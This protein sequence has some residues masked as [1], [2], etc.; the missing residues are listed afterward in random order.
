[1]RVRDTLTPEAWRGSQRDT[2]PTGSWVCEAGMLRTVAEAK[3]VDL[4]TRQQY[5][6]FALTLE[7][8][9]ARGGKSGI[10]LQHHGA[11]VWFRPLPDAY[12]GGVPATGPA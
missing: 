11:P 1:M 3:P 8:R 12:A 10:A 4:I 9:V 7:W 2:F 5:R 6:H